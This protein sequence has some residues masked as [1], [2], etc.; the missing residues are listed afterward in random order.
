[1][2]RKKT[3]KFE[4]EN[5][6]VDDEEY[7]MKLAEEE[8]KHREA[9]EAA[10][11]EDEA[12]RRKKAKE[13]E[14]EREKRIAQERLELLQLKNGVI[15]ES[16]ATIKEEHEQAT[17][18]T[19]LAWLE[20]FWYHNKYIILLIAFFAIVIGYISYKEFTRERADLTVLLIADDGL[21]LRQE[22]MEE[23][24]EKY[25]DDLDGNGYVHVSVICV[26]LNPD[27]DYET[28]D[29]NSSKFFAQLQAGDAMIVITDSNTEEQYKNLMN[30]TLA[31]DFPDNEYIDELGFSF[32]SKIMA[33][34]F[35]YEYMPND[36]HMSI[37]YPTKT[38]DLSLE[39]STENY[40]TS[41]TV[42]KR[43]VEDITQRCEETNDPGLE[44]EPVKRESSDESSDSTESNSSE[45]TTEN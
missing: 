21:E 7:E 1:M 31:E 45:S 9:L 44:T 26:P 5:L 3:D 32:N 38:L 29:A 16:E 15:D 43:I 11:A 35:R 2:S 13:A 6:V 25:T 30:S 14:H 10:A 24:F 20:N 39:E 40:N 42:F 12:M 34:E 33:D 22:E 4:H 8:R 23:F 18:L 36:V 41:F 19:G 27:G 37:R 28:Q 17:K